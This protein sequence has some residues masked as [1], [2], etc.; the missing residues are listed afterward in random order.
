[1]N[2]E[3]PQISVALLVIILTTISV[4]AET[5]TIDSSALVSINISV[6][7]TNLT[8]LLAL[9]TEQLDKVDV[10]RMNR[11]C[12]EGLRGGKNLNVGKNIAALEGWMQH[13]ESKTRRNHH[14][15]TENPAEYKNSEAYYQMAMLTMVSPVT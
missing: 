1:M 2:R 7:P 13:V 5:N 15:F 6:S 9:P 14:R 4:F 12:A 3:S 10:A 11:L 8:Q